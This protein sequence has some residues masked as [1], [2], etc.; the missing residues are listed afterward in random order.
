LRECVQEYHWVRR[1]RTLYPEQ[2]EPGEDRESDR[3]RRECAAAKARSRAFKEATPERPT[4]EQRS[5]ANSDQQIRN[6]CI[7]RALQCIPAEQG[8]IATFEQPG[9]EGPD[10][11]EEEGHH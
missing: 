1:G 7:D 11:K 3:K 10:A 9:G 8:F 4:K 5:A 6:E 2:H